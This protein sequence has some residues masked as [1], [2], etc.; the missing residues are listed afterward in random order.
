M[1]KNERS[2]SPSYNLKTKTKPSCFGGHRS[3]EVHTNNQCGHVVDRK[4]C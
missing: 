2:P 4:F 1:K 3:G